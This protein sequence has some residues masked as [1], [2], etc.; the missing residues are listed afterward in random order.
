MPT[1]KAHFDGRAIVPDQP[2]NLVQGQPLVVQFE[3][4]PEAGPPQSSSKHFL[5]WVVE[6]LVARTDLPAD[7]GT[8]HDH[9]LYGTPG[10][11]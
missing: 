9:Y 3:P 5:E 10:H 6:N 2:L 7:G 8:E 1:I 4:A 11:G